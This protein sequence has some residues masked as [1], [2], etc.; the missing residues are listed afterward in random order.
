[1][2][3]KTLAIFG[4]ATYIL[5]VMSSATDSAGNPSAPIFLIAISVLATIGFYIMAISRLWKIQK[6]AAILLISSAIILVILSVSQ[7][8]APLFLNIVK[9][10]NFIAFVWSVSL[11]WAM[12][13]HKDLPQ[14]NKNITPEIGKEISWAD[15]VNH[16]FRAL[17]FDRN[18][19]TIDQNYQVK[20]KSSFQPYGYLL[21][22]S[23]ILNQ[24]VRIPIIH[25][26]DFL[27]ADSVFDQPNFATMGEEKELLVTYAPK[28][29]MG[30]LPNS[31][32]KEKAKSLTKLP[33]DNF[34]FSFNL[35]LFLIF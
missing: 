28:Q 3:N 32:L 15:I 9:I 31:T 22:E 10:I 1:M 5:S 30:L 29:L 14:R 26:D 6:I 7:D 16:T 21:A 13:K 20:A 35:P 27:L 8:V 17:E 2:E 25:R 23:P 24:K 33:V 18:G 19:T 4:I 11:F 12:S 34:A